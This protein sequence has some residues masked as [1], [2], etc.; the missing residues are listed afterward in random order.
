MAISTK[1][2]EYVALTYAKYFGRTADAD[3]ISNYAS[4]GKTS[5]ILK[6]II[7]DSNIEQ[8]SVHGDDLKAEVHNEFQ[9]LFSRNADNKELQKYVKVLQKGKNLPINSIVKK[10][11]KFDKDVYD[12]KQEIAEYVAKNGGGVFDLS[13]VTKTN[14]IKV[15]SLTSLDDLRAKI[16]ALPDN[17]GIASSFDGKT[18]SLTASADTGS[19]FVGTEK[20]DIYY[21]FDTLVGG[22]STTAVNAFEI[23]L[24]STGAGVLLKLG[25]NSV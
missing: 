2:K 7:K 9:N 8:Y 16:D 15:E 10:A 19:K 13:K 4:I 3:T 17:D 12:N 14:P 20:G 18:F 6:Q 11:T 21:A 5:N 25:N 24:S 23:A 22:V 1:T